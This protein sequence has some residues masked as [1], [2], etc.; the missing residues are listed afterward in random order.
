MDIWDV[1]SKKLV[2][3]GT[4]MN[5]S[6]TDNPA[7]MEKRIDKALKKMVGEWRK[8]KSKNAKKG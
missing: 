3:R 2:W 8:I 6:V 7:K 4:A 1:A 5:I